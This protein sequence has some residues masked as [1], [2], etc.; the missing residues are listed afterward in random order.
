LKYRPQI[1]TKDDARNI[2][3]IRT[4]RDKNWNNK[5]NDT[6]TAL[7]VNRRKRTYGI[8]SQFPAPVS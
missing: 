7:R 5:G 1:Q 4:V 2:I 6:G 3:S 8:S